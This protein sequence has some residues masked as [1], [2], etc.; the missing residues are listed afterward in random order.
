MQIMCLS[1]DNI[2]MNTIAMTFS[3]HLSSTAVA[4]CTT[5]GDLNGVI[6]GWK[7][8]LHRRY[9]FNIRDSYG[10]GKG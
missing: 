9:H 5:H 4:N 8:S 1:G 7:V 2:E 6:V 3:A 10:N